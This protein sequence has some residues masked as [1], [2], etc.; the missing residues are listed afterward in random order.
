MYGYIDG[1]D[2]HNLD[3]GEILDIRKIL[4]RAIPKEET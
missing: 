4:Q 2:F 1:I 3:A